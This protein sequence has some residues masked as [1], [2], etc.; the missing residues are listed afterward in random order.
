MVSCDISKYFGKKM[1]IYRHFDSIEGDY[2]A[3]IGVFDGVHRG[4]QFLLEHLR[5][6]ADRRGT[7]SA[8]VTFANHPRKLVQPDFPLRL[9]D[10]LEER[11]EKLEKTGIDACFLLDFTDEVRMLSAERFIK[12]ILSS[13]LHIRQLLIG[14]DHRFGHNR[15]EGFFDYVRYGRDCGMEVI[16]EPV[17]ED[18]TG[19]RFSS[20]KVRQCLQEG[21]VGEAMTLLG[22]PYRI[23]GHVVHGHQLGRQL[24]FPTANLKPASADKIRPLTGV[25]AVHAVLDDGTV[26]PAMVNIGCRPTVDDKKEISLEAHVIGYEGDLY[27]RQMALEFIARLRDER[28]MESL[29]ELKEQLQRDAQ[30]AL[31]LLH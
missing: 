8:V 16:Q 15:A 10:T 21:N 27:G 24:G 31:R 26:W 9:I 18:G 28:R 3:C 25:Y 30:A 12:E 13:R 1:T 22:L 23:A 6:E 2:T 14:Y 4:H 29:E 17:Y 11:L 20:S 19:I 5:E 7:L